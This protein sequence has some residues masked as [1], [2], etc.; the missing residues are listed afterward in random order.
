MIANGTVAMVTGGTGPLG[1]AVVKDLASA[2]TK[3]TVPYRNAA[4]KDEMLIELGDLARNV[5]CVQADLTAV[6]DVQKLVD[7][8]VAR[9]GRI[10]ALVNLAGLF[11]GGKDVPTTTEDEWDK[12]MQSNLKTTFLCCR[13][14]LPV[15]LAKNHGSI[16]SVSA[17]PGIEN[18]L[19][20]KYSAYAI[21]KAGVAILTQ[22]IAD[23][24]KKTSV[25]ANAIAPNTIDTPENRKAM[26]DADR[27]KWTKPEDVSRVIM[28]LISEESNTINGA[29]I[30][31]Y[32]KA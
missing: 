4:A 26:P 23:E 1:R 19:R 12:M 7:D 21:S 25:R 15:M 29:V 13:A 14:V 17:R 2:G 16:V 18:R 3:I 11:F 31:V 6:S 9:E 30:P 5:T 22:T 10:D 32:G 20:A 24:V 8:V 28:F 27:T